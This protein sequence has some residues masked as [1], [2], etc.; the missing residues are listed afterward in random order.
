MANL[1]SDEDF[2]YPVV[3]ELRLL[4]HDVLT[5]Q[6]AGRANLGVAD[7][8]VLA[9]AIAQVRAVLTFNRRDFIRLHR[10]VLAHHGIIVCT[11]DDDVK[12]LALRVDRSIESCTSL[13]GQLLRIT[14]PQSP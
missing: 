14:R 3:Q 13:D 6:E 2:S 7:S 8:A 5:T 1:Y 11:R 4:G 12:G 10:S 9:F